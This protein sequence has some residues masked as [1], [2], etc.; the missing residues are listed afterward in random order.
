MNQEQAIKPSNINPINPIVN[1]TKSKS[2]CIK[3]S[4]RK[5]MKKDGTGY[6]YL[7]T[8]KDSGKPIVATSSTGFNIGLSIV[9]QTPY[10]PTVKTS[11][12][13][14]ESWC[15]S[16][17]EDYPTEETKETEFN[18]MLSIFTHSMNDSSTCHL[19]LDMV[20][21]EQ[22]IV[23]LLNEEEYNLLPSS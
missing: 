6:V 3:A 19:Y 20:A 12:F 11:K 15:F 1:P 18:N 5:M 10:N 23:T 22:N 14:Y 17:S 8:T 7:L 16:N 2:Q 9:K 21:F 4:I 13:H